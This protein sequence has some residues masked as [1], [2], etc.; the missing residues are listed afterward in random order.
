MNVICGNV[1]LFSD[2]VSAMY[3]RE[4]RIRVVA[5]FGREINVAV[6]GSTL[7]WSL[8]NDGLHAE[9]MV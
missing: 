8:L 7:I 4:P 2:F 6:P 5:P 3:V 1:S 9:L